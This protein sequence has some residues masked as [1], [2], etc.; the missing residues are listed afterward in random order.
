MKILLVHNEYREPGGEEKVVEAEA[1]LLR[2]RG[3]DVK[4]LR[5]RSSEVAG[6]LSKLKVAW[7]LPHS[8]ESKKRVAAEIAAFRPQLMHVHNFFPLATPSVFEAA[9]EANVR[10]VLTLHNYRILCAN[11]LFL[12][13]GKPCELCVPE[14]PGPAVRYRCYQKSLV[15]SVAVARMIR[16]HR[17]ER[18]WHE[19]VDRFIVLTE[20]SKSRYSKAGL[21]MEK[22]RVKP[23]FLFEPGKADSA[24]AAGN[25]QV[26]FVGRLSGEK[27]LSTLLAAK[28][29][30]K[31]FELHIV[32]EG[33]QAPEVQV[34]AAKDQS[35][36]W[37][38]R[39]SS[40][41][42]YERMRAASLVVFPSECYENFP[43]VLLEAM[44]LARPVLVSKIGG[45]PE[46]VEEGK[47]GR[48]FPP[49]NPRELA[50]AIQE[51]IDSPTH[52]ATMGRAGRER[53]LARYTA[54]KNISQLKEIYEGVAG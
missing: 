36:I 43:I 25:F 52:T 8:E 29:I 30:S 31:D 19:M 49:G 14:G 15:G 7:Q 45:L 17:A 20:F 35:I 9:R 21:P 47:T 13:D 46:I 22:F 27:G 1:R 28:K 38:G 50:R 18:T 44:A 48:L 16:H 40:E 51:M 37:H 54:E 26:L 33:P 42:V 53:F 12:R 24:P 4:E 23:N 39:L 41:K 3:F 32:G 6:P 10:S 34:A 11:G 2:E 5:F